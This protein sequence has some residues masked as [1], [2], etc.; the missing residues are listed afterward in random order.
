MVPEG[1]WQSSQESATCRYPESAQSSP[2]PLIL[3]LEDPYYQNMA[4]PEV[5]D[6]ERPPDMQGAFN[7][8]DKQVTTSDKGRSCSLGF[9]RGSNNS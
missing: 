6:G 8:L 9:G 5:A 7:I 1:L 3:F 2:H 4:H